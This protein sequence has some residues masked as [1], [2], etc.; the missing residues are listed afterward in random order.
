MKKILIVLISILII[1]YLLISDYKINSNFNSL[2]NESILYK[3]DMTLKT[4]CNQSKIKMLN[5]NIDKLKEKNKN[6]KN[7]T[8]KISVLY[9]SENSNFL[10]TINYLKENKYNLI[11]LE[12]YELWLDKK[13][14]LEEKSVL[15]ISDYKINDDINVIGNLKFNNSNKVSFRNSLKDNINS[16]KVENFNLDNLNKILNKEDMYYGN[17]EYIPV[18]NYHFFYDE[19][20]E[21]CDQK[22]CLKVSKFEEQLKYLYDNGYKTLTIDEFSS[23]MY[24]EIELPEKSVLITVDDGAMGTSFTN[25]NKLIPLL[26]KYNLNATLFLVTAWW[27]PSNYISKNLDIESHGNDLHKVGSCNSQNIKCLS[28]DEIYDDIKKS[29]DIVNSYTAFCFPFYVHTPVADLALQNLGVKIA[30]GHGDI[31]A[32]RNSNKYYIPRYVM[33]ENVTLEQYINMLN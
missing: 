22:I 4:S 13:I 33:Y 1:F 30:F 6:L 23:W 3:K 19:N 5:N 32:S 9:F 24:N 21:S 29:M 14:N 7:P 15:L 12:K 31:K 16:Y 18:L 25:G 17:S 2:I 8:N 11:S 28:Y 27:D 26:E 10:E 20:S